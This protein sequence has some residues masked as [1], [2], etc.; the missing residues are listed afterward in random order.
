[1]P[2]RYSIEDSRTY[3]RQSENPEWPADERAYRARRAVE[4]HPDS[5][6][7]KVVTLRLH[8]HLL[9]RV[10]RLVPIFKS[11][12]MLAPNGNSDRSSVIRSLIELGLRQYEDDFEHIIEDDG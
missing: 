9:E 5:S 12:E 7:K 8:K 11:N 1:M 3:K 10:D 4:V 2:R 6:Y